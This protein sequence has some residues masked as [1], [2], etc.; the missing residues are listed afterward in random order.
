MFTT[1]DF[2]HYTEY[3]PASRRLYVIRL[4]LIRFQCMYKT[5][6]LTKERERI[7]LVCEHLDEII[8]YEE[9]NQ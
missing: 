4:L 8:K 2:K 5:M 6:N 7:A 1:N 9:K 3:P